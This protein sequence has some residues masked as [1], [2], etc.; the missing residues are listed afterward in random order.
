MTNDPTC[1]CNNK[2]VASK[3]NKKYSLTFK[4]NYCAFEGEVTQGH[5]LTTKDYI[6]LIFKYEFIEVNVLNQYQPQICV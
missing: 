5:N 2:T 4:S 1:T 6:M 3:D